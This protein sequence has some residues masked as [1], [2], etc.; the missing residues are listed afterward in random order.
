MFGMGSGD[1]MNARA[2]NWESDRLAVKADE[3]DQLRA[4]AWTLPAVERA[5]ERARH[6]TRRALAVVGLAAA[7]AVIWF[8]GGSVAGLIA[9]AVA[10]ATALALTIRWQMR[11]SSTL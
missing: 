3:A 9:G 6:T 11:S 5:D 8:L 4:D 10:G 7:V 2:E 1:R